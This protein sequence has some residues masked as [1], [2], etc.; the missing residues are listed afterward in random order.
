[1]RYPGK[2]VIGAFE[3]CFDKRCLFIY[4]T[5]TSCNGYMIRKR[6]WK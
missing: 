2:T 5:F 4:K 6:N 1:M 3:A